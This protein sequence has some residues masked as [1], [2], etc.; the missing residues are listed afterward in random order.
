MQEQV[1]TTPK[2]ELTYWKIRGNAQ[3]IRNLMEYLGMPYTDNFIEMPK[4]IDPKQV[5]K[6]LHSL[7]IL[8]DEDFT[9]V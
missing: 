6:I 7:P 9:I 2:L 3:V 4:N 8:K 5:S 1:P